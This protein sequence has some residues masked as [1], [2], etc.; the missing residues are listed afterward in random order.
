V[1]ASGGIST[2]DRS[3]FLGDSAGLA[4]PAFCG[5]T[6]S[7]SIGAVVQRKMPSALPIMPRVLAKALCVEAIKL[8]VFCA[9]AL[10]E[11]ESKLRELIAAEWKAQQ[12]TDAVVMQLM[13]LSPHALDQAREIERHG[14]S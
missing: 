2:S 7:V 5:D 6:R 8:A 9:K 3:Q 12:P 1:H 13:H 10:N 14:D 11:S 4:R